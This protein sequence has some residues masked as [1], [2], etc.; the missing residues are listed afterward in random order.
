[1]TLTHMPV[2]NCLQGQHLA[3]S[4]GELPCDKTQGSVAGWQHKH[5]PTHSHCQHTFPCAP[6]TTPVSA[7]FLPPPPLV[8]DWAPVGNCTPLVERIPAC[9]QY[10][11]TLAWCTCTKGVSQASVGS[12]I[13]CHEP[14]TQQDCCIP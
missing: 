11:L 2:H 3:A 7:N 4:M 10:P 13:T 8:R 5:K 14:G 9:C 12:S 1:M 6:T